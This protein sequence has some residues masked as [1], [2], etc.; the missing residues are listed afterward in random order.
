MLVCT[1]LVG[2]RDDIRYK[3]DIVNYQRGYANEFYSQRQM[4]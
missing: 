1:F 2:C 3:K 4:L